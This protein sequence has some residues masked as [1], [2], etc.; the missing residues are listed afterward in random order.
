MENKHPECQTIL[1]ESADEPKTAKL[2]TAIP[3]VGDGPLAANIRG[4]LRMDS[5]SRLVPLNRTRRS[6]FK[7]TRYPISDRNLHQLAEAQINQRTLRRNC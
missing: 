4:C 7:L 3:P 2:E 5:R 6:F 1:F